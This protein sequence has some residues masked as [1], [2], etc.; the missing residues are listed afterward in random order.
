M[1]SRLGGEHGTPCGQVER[2]RWRI[3]ARTT[4]SHAQTSPRCAFRERPAYP[5]FQRYLDAGSARRKP[6]K[7]RDTVTRSLLRSTTASLPPR[8]H[9]SRCSLKAHLHSSLCDPIMKPVSSIGRRRAIIWDV[10]AP[11]RTITTPRNR[12][13]IQNAPRLKRGVIPTSSVKGEPKGS[14]LPGSMKKKRREEG[15]PP[16]NAVDPL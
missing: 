8:A 3:D 16:K 5:C 2:G 9:A 4:T 11:S 6:M 13:E 12:T 10:Y 14:W 1:N 15:A 7:S